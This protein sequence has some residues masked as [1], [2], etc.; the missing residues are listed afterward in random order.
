MTRYI[1]QRLLAAI[2]VLLGVSITVFIILHLVPGDIAYALAGPNATQEELAEVRRVW[3]LDQPIYLQYFTWLTRAL[4]GDLGRSA[5]QHDP[6]FTMIMDRFPNTFLLAIASLSISSIVGIFAGV[7][8]ATRQ[9]SL[10]DR[11]MML[12]AL[13]G[14]SMP[15]FWLGLVLIMIFALWL[16]VFPSGGMTDVRGAGGLLDLLHHLILPAVT[17]GTV[18]MAIVARLV[19]STM[20][21][22]LR[23][24]YIRTAKAKGLVDRVVVYRHALRNALLPVITVIGL[25]TGFLM[26]GAIIVETIFSWPGLGQMMYRAISSRDTPV[27]MGGVLLLA[28]VFVFVN[29]VVDICYAFLD[30]RI[31]YSN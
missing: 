14:N 10:W 7:I 8:S 4:R 25:Q 24:D 17:L 23:Q 21:E 19:R 5:L 28:T 9:Y 2:P 1:I 20:L 29:L 31:K 12:L 22:V 18:S 11:L 13:F 6:V 15:S 16:R 3:G 30:P 26:G 27:V